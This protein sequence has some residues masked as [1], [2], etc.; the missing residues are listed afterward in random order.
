MGLDL[1]PMFIGSPLKSPYEPLK[2]YLYSWVNLLGL[3]PT[4]VY[5][6]L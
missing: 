2:P 6:L 5:C 4:I 3:L 1:Y